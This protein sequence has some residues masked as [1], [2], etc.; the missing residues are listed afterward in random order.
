MR[1][2]EIPKC[3]LLEV[4]ITENLLAVSDGGEKDI[5]G[6]SGSG[7]GGFVVEPT[8]LNDEKIGLSSKSIGVDLFK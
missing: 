6:G 1:I 7:S 3:E 8:S 2:Y 4:Q 5:G